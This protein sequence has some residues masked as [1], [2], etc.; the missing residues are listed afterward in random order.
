MS[1]HSKWHNIKVRKMAVDAKRGKIYTKHARLIEIAVREGGLKDPATNP[2]LRTAL[3]NARSD[4]VPNTII[5]RA[6]KKGAGE[7]KEGARMEELLYEAFGPAGTA[8]LI[9]VLT[10]NRNRTLSNVKNILHNHGGRMA[11]HGA[12]S[13]MFE[14]KGVVIA[15]ITGKP[16]EEIELLAIDAGAEDLEVD[17]ELL[18]ATSAGTT[19][20]KVR[21]AL[22][23]AGCAIEEAGLKFVPTNVVEVSD[24]VT[25][26]RIATL[27]ESLEEDE[28]VCEVH[29]NARCEGVKVE[30]V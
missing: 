7:G 8:Y 25:S 20:G 23:L 15:H 5:E 17:G 21:D 1:G 24:T 2:R 30:K 6:M 27:L 28:D 16:I 18:H 9:E 4:S 10:D 29:S 12:V 11:E 26:E 13:W 19:W 3:E 22:K 14:K